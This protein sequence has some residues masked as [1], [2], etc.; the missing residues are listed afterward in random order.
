M[1]KTLVK[2]VIES[3]GFSVV[4][5]QA[6]DRLKKDSQSAYDIKLLKSVSGDKVW[7]LV[8]LMGESKSQLRQDLFVLSELNFKEGGFFVE[9]GA[10]NGVDLSNTYILEKNFGWTGLLGEPA[11]KWHTSLKSNRSSVIETKCVWHTSGQELMFNEADVGEL[12]TLEQF[13]KE[14]GHSTSRKLSKQYQVKTI[15][16]NDFLENNNAPALM[17]FLS[18][19]TEGSEYEILSSLDFSRYKFRVITC[20]HNY[21]EAREKIHTLLTS[22]GYVRKL[23]QVSRWDD[24]YVLDRSS[25]S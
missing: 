6:L 24:W 8:D 22:H 19:D 11:R 2:K 15:S 5:L 17:D 9:F 18:I 13:V 12:S 16:F 23:E 14:D 21:T 25:V 7:K 20:E 4:R 10:T 1:A 3:L